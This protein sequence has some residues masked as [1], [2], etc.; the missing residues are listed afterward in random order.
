MRRRHADVSRRKRP[1]RPPTRRIMASAKVFTI[2][3]RRSGLAQ[4]RFSSGI[5]AN[6][7][8]CGAVIV[9]FSFVTWSS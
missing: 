6:G 1:G 9:L 7:T 3:R 5:A 8:L 2:W 4:A